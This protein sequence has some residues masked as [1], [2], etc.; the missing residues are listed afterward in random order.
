MAFHWKPAV[1]EKRAQQKA[2]IPKEWIL[3]SPVPLEVTNVKEFIDASDYLTPEEKAIT[4]ILDAS[5]L[6]KK[7]ASRELSSEQVARAFCKRTA[8]AHQV[9]NC[10]TEIFFD[11][12]I[13]SAKALDAHLAATGKLKGPLHGLPISIKDGFDLEGVDTTLGMSHH[14]RWS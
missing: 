14:N 5:V 13:A 10:C 11:R 12:A 6:L 9:I 1:L 4:H 7:L 8:L 3:T 2:S